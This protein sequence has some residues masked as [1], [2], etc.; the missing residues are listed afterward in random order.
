MGCSSCGQKRKSKSNIP[1]IDTSSKLLAENYAKIHKNHSNTKRTRLL[2]PKPNGIQKAYSNL[3]EI[4]YTGKRI[5]VLT[6]KPNKSVYIIGHMENCGS[7]NYMKRLLNNV[8][9]PE[10]KRKI[11]FYVL[12]QGITEPVGF[13]FASNPTILFVN[14]GKLIF[15][16]GGIFQNIQ[17]KI[18]QMFS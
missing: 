17:A 3:T 16:V 10:L 6:Y 12:D 8:I 4:E 18:I 11:G 15:Q 5:N 9:T 2:N 13:Q 14:K 7:C 1:Y